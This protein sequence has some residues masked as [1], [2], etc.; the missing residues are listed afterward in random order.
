MYEQRRVLGEKEGD[1][2]GKVGDVQSNVETWAASRRRESTKG[3]ESVKGS[4]G[5]STPGRRA[6]RP[7]RPPG[8]PAPAGVGGWVAKE[9]WQHETSEPD[10]PSYL[11]NDPQASRQ[12]AHQSPGSIGTQTSLLFACDVLSA[13]EKKKSGQQRHV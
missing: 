8:L 11:E 2:R 5:R 7:A 3:A 9:V 12:R 1:V 10:H 6:S 4:G 13:A